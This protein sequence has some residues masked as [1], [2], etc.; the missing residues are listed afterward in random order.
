MA[1]TEYLFSKEME[2]Y[3]ARTKEIM[4]KHPEVRKL[5]GKRNP[6]SFAA[7]LFSVGLQITVAWFLR[8]QPLWIVL[9]TAYF[10]GTLINHCYIS[11]VHEAS[12][13]AI[14]RGRILNDIAG[15]IVNMPMFI[16]SYV[17]FKKYHMKH[18]A[19]QGVFALDADMPDRWEVKIVKNVWYRKAIW[20]L[21]F[22]L[23]QT[24]RTF[25]V[26]EV[27]FF[28][29]WV[30]AN[31]LLTMGLDVAIAYFF[32]WH[33]FIYIA[34]S[35]WF[36]FGLSIV[37]GRLIQEHF[38]VA[39]PQ[40]TYSYY[41]LLNIPS[42]N[43]G[44][45]NE[46]H[47]FPSTSWNNLPKITKMAP[48]YYKNIVYHKSWGLLVLKFIFDKNMSVANRVIRNERGGIALD[49]PVEPDL[50]FASTAKA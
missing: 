6:W 41:G 49:A 21:F 47:D 24:L 39:E 48:E 2:P 8:D 38:M 9:L 4:A 1:R 42:L 12:H 45:H 44:Y 15:L 27:Q 10:V 17:S 18:H 23:W 16:P 20:L 43:V 35:F 40:E 36:A 7:I 5:L 33:S 19:F 29:R 26:T 25:R 32:G 30:V 22:P 46:H 13:A 31:W 28:D 14:F 3:R 50:E 37:G 34:A 11:L